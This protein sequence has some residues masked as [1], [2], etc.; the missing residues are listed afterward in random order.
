METVFNLCRRTEKCVRRKRVEVSGNDSDEA[1]RLA[2]THKQLLNQY[3]VTLTR[4]REGHGHTL[5]TLI[6]DS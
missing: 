1:G 2:Q 5:S 3:S 4:E 6:S